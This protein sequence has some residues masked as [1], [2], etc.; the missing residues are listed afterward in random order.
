[1][2]QLIKAGKVKFKIL[3]FFILTIVCSNLSCTSDGGTGI[4]GIKA[5]YCNIT[6]SLD[7]LVC[8]DYTDSYDPAI[9]D[10][11][12]E[13]TLYPI[14]LTSQTA[15]GHGYTAEGYG[16]GCSTVDLVPGSCTIDAGELYYYTPTY[17]LVSAD[18][19]CTAVHSGT[20]HF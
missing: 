4:F 17:N 20:P 11:Y 14:Y 2:Y 8:L 18:L 19:D 9:A 12:C 3:T 15:T 1:M 6:K 16:D 10:I 13:S 7:D 5:G